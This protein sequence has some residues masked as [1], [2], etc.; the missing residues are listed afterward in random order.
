M[1][2]S[3]ERAQTKAYKHFSLY[4]I[5]SDDATAV[6]ILC[7]GCPICTFWLCCFELS[8]PGRIQVLAI[9][10]VSYGLKL[11]SRCTFKGKMLQTRKAHLTLEPYGIQ[12]QKFTGFM[13]LRNVPVLVLPVLG[14]NKEKK[15]GPELLNYNEF[16]REIS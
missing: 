8:V 12:S 5:F 9:T 14:K 15:S 4:F 7:S 11:F 10:P 16:T 3:M 6:S 2:I 13:L 1:T